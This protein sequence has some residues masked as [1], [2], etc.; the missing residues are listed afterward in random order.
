MKLCD[1][2]GEDSLL[3]FK[4]KLR[5]ENWN[6]FRPFFKKLFLHSEKT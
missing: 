2:K 6:Y 1:V 4:L 3:Q 5:F